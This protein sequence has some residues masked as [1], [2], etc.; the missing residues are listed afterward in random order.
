ME[1]VLGSIRPPIGSKDSYRF[2]HSGPNSG[3][4]IQNVYDIIADLWRRPGNRP[5]VNEWPMRI[6]KSRQLRRTVTFL[7]NQR[8]ITELETA[9]VLI[10]FVVVAAA[11]A[12]AVLN[13]GLL[14]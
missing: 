1:G 11:F 14:S 13:A 4:D 9:I 6:G 8:G 7:Q 12:F 10:S 3:R 2:V 5:A